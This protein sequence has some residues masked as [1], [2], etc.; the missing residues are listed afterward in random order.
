MSSRTTTPPES[1]STASALTLSAPAPAKSTAL[2]R[3]VA[4]EKSTKSSKHANSALIESRDATKDSPRAKHSLKQS[5]ESLADSADSSTISPRDRAPSASEKPRHKHHDNREG[6]LSPRDAEHKRKK[7]KKP[8]ESPPPSLSSESIAT[9]S[10][11]TLTTDTS[12]G[13]DGSSPWSTADKALARPKKS[14][15]A[16][17]AA[18]RSASS[19]RSLTISP[20]K[21]SDPMEQAESAHDIRTIRTSQDENDRAA[22]KSSKEGK[23]TKKDRASAEVSATSPRR[24]ARSYSKASNSAESAD[25]VAAGA[26][27]S[28]EEGALM[29]HVERAS[30]VTPSKPKSARGSS[31]HPV[32]KTPEPIPISSS[33][34]PTVSPASS[35]PHRLRPSRVNRASIHVSKRVNTLRDGDLSSELYDIDAPRSNKREAA[36]TIEFDSSD[37]LSRGSNSNSTEDHA[38]SRMVKR[39]T[40]SKLPRNTRDDRRATL[41]SGTAGGSSTDFVAEEAYKTN[42]I[43][44]TNGFLIETLREEPSDV[45]STAQ[46][47]I[48]YERW[49]LENL[50]TTN[51]HDTIVHYVPIDNVPIEDILF[52]TVKTEYSKS[53]QHKEITGIK[54]LVTFEDRD[55][56]ITISNAQLKGGHSVLKGSSRK[57]I[58]VSRLLEYIHPS[59]AKSK[60]K[61]LKQNH[62]IVE[63]LLTLARLRLSYCHAERQFKVGVVYWSGDKDVEATLDQP[64]SAAFNEFVSVLGES[65]QLENWEKFAGGLDTTS[66]LMDGKSSLFTEWKGNELMYHV[67]PVMQCTAH[68]RRVHI[69][70]DTLVVVFS[71]ST[72]PFKAEYIHSKF[73][74]VFVVVSPETDEAAIAKAAAAANVP[75]PPPRIPNPPPLTLSGT[76]LGPP[77]SS[78]KKKL[79]SPNHASTANSSL[80]RTPGDRRSYG[81]VSPGTTPSNRRE[82]LDLGRS[83]HI[84]DRLSSSGSPIS[85][86]ASAPGHSSPLAAPV[87]ELLEQ[88]EDSGAQGDDESPVKP[89]VTHGSSLSG[90]PE[91]K[92]P[93]IPLPMDHHHHPALPIPEPLAALSLV[94]AHSPPNLPQPLS[95]QFGASMPDFVLLPPP[96]PPPVP[97]SSKRRSKRTG[98]VA[99]P[100]SGATASSAPDLNLAKPPPT[101]IESTTATR[102]RKNTHNK[103]EVPV[104]PSAI[105]TTDTWYRVAV[106]RRTGIE[107]FRPKMPWPSVMRHGPEFREWLLT[108]ITS[109]MIAAFSSPN[110]QDRV[111][112]NRATFLANLT[113]TVA[114]NVKGDA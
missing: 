82:S 95:H 36:R 63:G 43:L 105:P 80:E 89:S 77:P 15:Q 8:K 114:N 34:L 78:R 2:S 59:L 1:S 28:D 66:R 35:S 40:W 53:E 58:S 98:P 94:E 6:S 19:A 29:D 3:N 16:D 45:S 70:N 73:N 13:V 12:A 111:Q 76:V 87:D 93:A 55:Q 24:R 108:K 61:K 42:R 47:E 64:A 18:R 33:P 27:E 99:Y 32:S 51:G 72:K 57:T 62:E 112:A 5:K 31:K 48:N 75:P 41:F 54:V 74:Q 38:D 67:A 92:T 22:R 90:S 110:F 100:D 17:F 9:E 69:G 97:T 102:K 20:L 25:D 23:S 109:G 60:M 65:V 68:Q 39:K 96:P 85:G 86:G 71:D 103:S 46:N 106:L 21:S 30:L 88:D 49:L 104:S 107:P 101:I 44:P 50:G 11:A 83:P 56:R 79:S 52:V 91:T 81:S 14:A 113:R 10:S 7:K 84:I 26:I 37:E 4:T